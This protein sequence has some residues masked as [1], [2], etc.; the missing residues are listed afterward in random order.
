M[1]QNSTK[2]NLELP[3]SGMC[4]GMKLQLIQLTLQG[5]NWLIHISSAIA[6][7][8]AI[9]N[10]FESLTFVLF[11]KPFFLSSNIDHVQQ[12]LCI[13]VNCNSYAIHCS[14]CSAVGRLPS[15]C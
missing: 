4:V 14:V 10:L 6:T 1:V 13:T 11:S 8:P 3:L 2:E 5:G 12:G 15:S 9:Y 7:Q